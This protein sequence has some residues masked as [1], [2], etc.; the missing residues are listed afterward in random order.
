MVDS[1]RSGDV[2]DECAAGAAE[3]VVAADAGGEAEEALQ[4][5]FFDAGQGAGAVAFE[6]EQVFAGPEDRFDPLADRGEVW[7][8]AG[9]VGAAGAD[10]G[11]V[12]VLE[13][14]AKSRPA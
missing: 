4:D 5:A 11:G 1:T 6:G 9:F 13:A 8:L 7:L 10:D 14:W 3:L 12:E 2:V